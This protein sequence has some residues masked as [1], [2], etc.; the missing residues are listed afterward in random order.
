MQMTEQ[1][2]RTGIMEESKRTDESNALANS[3]NTGKDETTHF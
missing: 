3:G 2:I 1:S